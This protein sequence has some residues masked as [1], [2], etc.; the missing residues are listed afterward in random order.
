MPRMRSVQK[1]KVRKLGFIAAY[2]F[3]APSPLACESPK[4]RFSYAKPGN[5]KKGK[6][7]REDPSNIPKYSS[8]PLRTSSIFWTGIA[9]KLGATILISEL[10]S[11]AKR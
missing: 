5:R 7:G 4:S 6:V 8:V 9:L 11:H 10:P 2:F 1:K 3:P